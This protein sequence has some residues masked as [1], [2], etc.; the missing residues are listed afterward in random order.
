MKKH[1]F[2]DVLKD[3]AVIVRPDE[4][5]CLTANRVTV[6][7][8]VTSEIS[9]DQLGVYEIELNPMTIGAKLHYH[10]YMDETFIV[11][12]GVLTVQLAEEQYAAEPGTVVY[13]PRFT[14][15][16]FRNDSSE[17]VKLL[18]IFNPGQKREGFFRGLH[19]ILNENPVDT[20]K[21]SKLYHQYDSI[22][23]DASDIIPMED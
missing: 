3:N 1:V 9:Y 23:V 21:F 12:E 15:H 22:P 18:L 8:K 14:A 10:R 19:E 7:L 17:N 4:G 20:D 2:E 13:V 16:G 6:T 5:E 11:K